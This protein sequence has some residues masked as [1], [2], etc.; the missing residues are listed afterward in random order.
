MKRGRFMCVVRPSRAIGSD[1]AEGGL[2]AALNV[3]DA[4]R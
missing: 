1:R 3:E 4:T 2:W